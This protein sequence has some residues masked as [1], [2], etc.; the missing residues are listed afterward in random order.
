MSFTSFTV[1]SQFRCVVCTDTLRVIPWS[2]KHWKGRIM[3]KPFQY[4]L[5]VALSDHG[6]TLR[7]SVEE[8]LG[9][10]IFSIRY[11]GCF[12]QQLV[13]K[14]M[15]DAVELP[16]RLIPFIRA[17]DIQGCNQAFPSRSWTTKWM[18]SFTIRSQTA[19]TP[20]LSFCCLNS[21][22][23]RL[24]L[25]PWMSDALRPVDFCVL[26]TGTSAEPNADTN[27]AAAVGFRG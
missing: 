2:N 4:W 15:F 19:I 21:V 24:A 8:Y 14:Q 10:R 6:T 26:V 13:Q 23:E 25:Y 7:V 22:W 11:Y 27:D 5:A 1:S 18:N 20:T 16:Q 3:M 12:L 9:S 17:F